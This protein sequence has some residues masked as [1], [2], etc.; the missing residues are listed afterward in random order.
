MTALRLGPFVRA[1]SESHDYARTV[2]RAAFSRSSSIRPL[3]A[4]VAVY[5]TLTSVS[6]ADGERYLS[7]W[8]RLLLVETSR[9]LPDGFEADSIALTNSEGKRLIVVETRTTLALYPRGILLPGQMYELSTLQAYALAHTVLVF[10]ILAAWP[11]GGSLRRRL[12]LLLLG[13]PCVLISTS[14]DIPFVLAG[15]ARSYVIHAFDSDRA[16]SDAWVLYA[17]FLNRG[18]RFGL[19][20]ALALLAA[21]VGSGQ[22][23]RKENT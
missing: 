9:L 18:G 17:G 6:F 2:A 22:A 20:V 16:G 11:A 14:L 10:A 12:V 7:V 8:L 21:V 13:V 5:A 23:H 4:L 3:L 1:R 15:S 19:I